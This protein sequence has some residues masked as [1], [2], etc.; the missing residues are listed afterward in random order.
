MTVPPLDTNDSASSHP[1]PVSLLTEPTKKQVRVAKSVPQPK[2][3]QPILAEQTPAS[4]AAPPAPTA[5]EWAIASTYTLKNSKRYRYNWGQQVRSMMG[6][7]VEGPQQGHVRFRIEIASDGKL[8]KIETLWSTSEVA[9]KLARH[10]MESL[11]PLPPPPDR[12]AAG[13]RTNHCLR[14]L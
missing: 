9:E 8:A 2:R 11:P 3:P 5:E 13:V 1:S 14:A 7:A 4:V 10:A 12:A 6:T